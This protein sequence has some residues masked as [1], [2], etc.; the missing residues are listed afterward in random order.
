MCVI[1]VKNN[2]KK[3]DEQIIKTSASV[4]PDGLGIVWLD[5]YEVSHHKS[6]EYGLL[7]TTRPFIAHFRYATIGKIGLSN[8][9]P[10]QCGNGAEEWLMMNGT[11]HGLGTIND[12]DTKVLARML[13]KK[14]R[15]E[16]KA[17]LENYDSR[18]LTFNTRTKSYQI[19]NRK[20]WVEHDGALYSKGNVIQTNLV[21]VYGTLKKGNSNYYRYLTDSQ[22]VGSGV[23]AD[24]YPLIINGLPYLIEHKGIGYNV[25]V[26][27][28]NVSDDVMYDLDILEGHP[29]WY[30]R[31]QIKIRVGKQDLLCWVYFMNNMDVEIGATI[32]KTYT[33]SGRYDVVSVHDTRDDELLC[34]NCLND[35]QYDMHDLYYCDAC[36][37]WWKENE[38][39]TFNGVFED[40]ENDFEI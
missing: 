14:P 35:V 24:R 3:I 22:F 12:C 36:G 9:H 2:S 10:F 30:E 28:F 15:H 29:R 4:N 18:F 26:D 5:T 11:I 34:V 13:G 40:T 33:Q 31:K 32:H 25:D 38:L 8:T 17:Y 27:V 16:W 21:A 6:T 7:N 19:Y 37:S 20:N 23:T 1:I 39:T